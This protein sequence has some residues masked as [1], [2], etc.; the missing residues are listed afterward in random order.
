MR[1]FYPLRPLTQTGRVTLAVAVSVFAAVL[2]VC[3]S[4]AHREPVPITS[5]GAAH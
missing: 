1:G 5:A 3:W 4:P 2:L